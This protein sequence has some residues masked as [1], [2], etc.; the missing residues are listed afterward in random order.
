MVL[1]LS[2]M[3]NASNIPHHHLCKHRNSKK[4]SALN[5]REK[6]VALGATGNLHS[7]F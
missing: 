6:V 7:T 1:M 5:I 2:F 4:A 3:Y